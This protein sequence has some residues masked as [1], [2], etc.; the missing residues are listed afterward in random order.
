MQD[1][2]ACTPMEYVLKYS[3]I[4]LGL[5]KTVNDEMIEKITTNEE[6]EF[7]LKSF[8]GDGELGMFLFAM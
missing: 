8:L 4:Y 2:H 5:K 6:N 1:R 3:L 7:A